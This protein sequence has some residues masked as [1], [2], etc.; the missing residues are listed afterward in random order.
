MSLFITEPVHTS[1]GPRWERFSCFSQRLKCD[2]AGRDWWG[3][4]GLVGRFRC[5]YPLRCRSHPSSL[6]TRAVPSRPTVVVKPSWSNT[7]PI[8]QS[9]QARK[10]MPGAIHFAIRAK[11]SPFASNRVQPY[12]M[13]LSW[14]GRTQVLVIGGEPFLFSKQPLVTGSWT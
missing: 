8:K 9:P 4:T 7:N 11:Y 14:S 5:L 6:W 2:W 12:N 1:P 3:G 13:P 10:Q